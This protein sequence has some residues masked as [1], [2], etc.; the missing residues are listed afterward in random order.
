MQMVYSTKK[1]S[2]AESLLIAWIV[3]CLPGVA[4]EPA[5]GES[6]IPAHSQAAPTSVEC[7]QGEAVTLGDLRDVGLAIMQIKQQ[8]INIFLDVT[9]K[10]LTWT[11]SPG[12]AFVSRIAPSD[13]HANAKYLPTR[14][15]WLVFY[16]GAMEPI[17]KLLQSDVKDVENGVAK[18]MVPKGCKEKFEKL[19]LD[20]K[21]DV[22]KLNEHLSKIYDGVG[23]KN[24]NMELARQ[25]IH[26][27]EVADDMEK[28]RV[29]A[30]QL[31]R[32]TSNAEM[33]ELPVP[34]KK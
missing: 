2:I 24:N 23:D 26:M 29:G 3:S 17:I 20:Y 16:V 33:E 22:A 19:Y 9:R 4:A 11:S 31:M 8:A 15:E 7:S 27:F 1:I 18:L 10:D 30:F 21:A 34:S 5:A 12:I 32:T 28:K 14:P 25:A 13:L 6:R